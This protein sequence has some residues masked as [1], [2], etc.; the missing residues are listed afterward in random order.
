MVSLREGKQKRND[1]ETKFGMRQM[2]AKKK[3]KRAVLSPSPGRVASPGIA[4]AKAIIASISS[5][6]GVARM[7]ISSL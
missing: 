6:K 3:S 7:E 2:T 5:S 4:A 1:L